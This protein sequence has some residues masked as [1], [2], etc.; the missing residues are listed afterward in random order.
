MVAATGKE[1]L[2]RYRGGSACEQRAAASGTQ[3]DITL[4]RLSFCQICASAALH[5]RDLIP[6][7]S[8]PNGPQTRT[9]VSLRFP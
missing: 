8:A 6:P 5:K 1:A 9:I 4:L 7:R 3:V 2:P